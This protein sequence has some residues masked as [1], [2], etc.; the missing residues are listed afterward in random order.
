MDLRS[1]PQFHLYIGRRS[2]A[3][4]LQKELDTGAMFGAA[5]GPA[6][7][8]KHISLEGSR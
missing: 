3:A 7:S 2:C 1:L 5:S 6:D 8:M 4:C